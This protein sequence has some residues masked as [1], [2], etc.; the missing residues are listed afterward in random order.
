MIYPHRSV[1]WSDRNEEY[2]I[3]VPCGKCLV[4]LSSKRSEWI[5]RLEQEFKFSSGAMFVTLTFDRRHYPS[6]G[7]ISKRDIQLYLKRL[8]KAI[9][10]KDGQ[11]RIR[12]FAVGEYGGKTGRAHY[13]ILLFNCDCESAVRS[14]WVDSKGQSIGM[15]HIGQVTQASIAYCTKYIVQPASE[16]DGILSPFRLM[17][18]AYGIGGMYLSDAM[19][20]WHRDGAKNYVM[21]DGVKCRLPRFYKSKIWYS[22]KDREAVS[23][24]ALV[25]S[26]QAGLRMEAALG[27][28]YGSRGPAKYIEMRDAML[29]R[30]R[31]KVAFSQSI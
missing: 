10:Q 2:P 29:S 13:H 28:K 27:K 16:V 15:V 12:Y 21:R 30:V 17:S 23:K 25:E 19:V 9:F 14:A 26:L 20:A 22:E 24:A 3:S 18:R 5:L 8:R 4:C 31:Q 6:N 7:S 1:D 11:V